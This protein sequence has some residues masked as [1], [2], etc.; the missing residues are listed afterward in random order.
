MKDSLNY[1]GLGYVVE[2]KVEDSND[3]KIYPIE[4]IPTATGN[5]NIDEDITTELKNILGEDISVVANKRNYITA[6]WLNEGNNNRITAPDVCKGEIVKLF[7]MYEGDDHQWSTLFT[8]PMLR[9]REKLI[10]YISNK[11]SIEDEEDLSKGYFLLID[12][13]NKKTIYHMSDNDGEFTSYDVSIDGKVGSFMVKDGRDN[14][15]EIAS[16]QDSLNVKMGKNVNIT[17]GGDAVINTTGNT[18]IKAD[19]DVVVKASKI[20]LN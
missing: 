7:N 6:S 9:K 11:A 8:K 10:I 5:L 4:L 19:G 18:N 2:D 14:K 3:I 13:I 20:K 12:S 15:I 1:I 17:C 16:H